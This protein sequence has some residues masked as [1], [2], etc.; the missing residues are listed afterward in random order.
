MLKNV[1]YKSIFMGD[2]LRY[3]LNA[4]HEETGEKRGKVLSCNESK[5]V[6]IMTSKERFEYAE[7]ILN[8]INEVKT[9]STEY[10][11]LV[12]TQGGIKHHQRIKAANE[13]DAIE[14]IHQKG[15]SVISIS[16]IR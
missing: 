8:P 11:D 6:H 2:G 10:F 1:Q 9:A 16:S 4:I 14:K 12:W 5:L 3:V 15:G 13:K 7:K